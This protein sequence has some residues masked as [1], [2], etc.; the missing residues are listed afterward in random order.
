MDISVK[1]TVSGQ[2]AGHISENDWI[3]HL[4]GLLSGRWL[5]ILVKWTAPGQVPG[6]IS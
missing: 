1:C 3:Y 5:D 4:N 2:V 6:H